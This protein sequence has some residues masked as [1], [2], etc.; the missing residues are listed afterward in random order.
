MNI[1]VLD[2]YT[3]SILVTTTTTFFLDGTSSLCSSIRL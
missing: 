3:Q 1:V 2:E